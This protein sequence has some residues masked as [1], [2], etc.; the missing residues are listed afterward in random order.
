M[1]NGRHMYFGE[2]LAKGLMIIKSEPR[3]L[4]YMGID[5]DGT[6][7]MLFWHSREVA[8]YALDRAIERQKREGIR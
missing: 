1:A 2:A 5:E 8:V 7:H 4:A 3:G 6:K